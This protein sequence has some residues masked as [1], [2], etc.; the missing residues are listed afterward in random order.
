MTDDSTVRRRAAAP[1][2]P[3][4]PSPSPSPPPTTKPTAPKSST[5]STLIDLL[6]ALVGLLLLSTLASYLIT[7]HPLWGL[8][9]P[10]LRSL[11]TRYLPPS[12]HPSPRF[13]TESELRKYDGSDASLPV[14]VALNGTVYDVS[15]GRATYAPGGSYAFF[16]GRDASRAFVTGCFDT[17]LTGDLRGLEEMFVPVTIAE[18]ARIRGQALEAEQA[19]ESEEEER[20]EARLT[21]GE[22]KARAERERREARKQVKETIAHWAKVFSGE[23]GRPYFEVGRVARESGWGTKRELCEKARKQRPARRWMSNNNRQKGK[24]GGGPP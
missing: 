21:G 11:L 14:Y 20:E 10:H 23:T 24:G 6:R 5:S 1:S 8:T 3:S 12:L 9:P 2:S 15:A 19:A 18:R 4:D 17:D 22:K 13:F 7:S 16:A